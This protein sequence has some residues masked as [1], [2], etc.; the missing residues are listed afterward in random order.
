MEVL[1]PMETLRKVAEAQTNV[2]QWGQTLPPA[3]ARPCPSCGSIDARKVR[4]VG[5]K[6]MLTCPT[7]EHEWEYR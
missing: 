6:L 2:A 5:R 1:Q 3:V 7:C 4:R